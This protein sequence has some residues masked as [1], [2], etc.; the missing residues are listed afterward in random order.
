ML[1]KFVFKLEDNDDIGEEDWQEYDEKYLE[2][3]RLISTLKDEIKY[4]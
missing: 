4:G 2:I 3:H 1:S